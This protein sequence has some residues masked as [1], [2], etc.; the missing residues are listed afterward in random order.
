REL[1]DDE[2]AAIVVDEVTV[3]VAHEVGGGIEGPLFGQRLSLPHQLARGDLET[4]QRAVV[5]QTV[6]I[7]AIDDRRT[8]RWVDRVLLPR[9]V[10]PEERRAGFGLVQL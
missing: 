9:I 4:P 2:L 8:G 6:D 5:A 3:A 10:R 7:V 1:R